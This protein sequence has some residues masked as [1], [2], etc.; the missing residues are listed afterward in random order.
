MEQIEF[1]KIYLDVDD[2]GYINLLFTGVKNEHRLYFD[3]I[4][5][6]ISN[7]HYDEFT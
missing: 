6:Y 1:N 3:G 5:F 4:S 7:N 2:I